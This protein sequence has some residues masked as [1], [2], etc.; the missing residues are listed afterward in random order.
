MIIFGGSGPERVEN[1]CVSGAVLAERTSGGLKRRVCSRESLCGDAGVRHEQQRQQVVCAGDG[2]RD[3]LPA[4]PTHAQM[5]TYRKTQT[6]DQ[7]KHFK[8][9]NKLQFT[10]LSRSDMLRDFRLSIQPSQN[11]ELATFKPMTICGH[12]ACKD[13]LPIMFP[14]YTVPLS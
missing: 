10:S 2:W 9:N 11:G 3:C 6:H 12:L 13:Y 4:V 14:V 1:H 8:N 5:H 7:R